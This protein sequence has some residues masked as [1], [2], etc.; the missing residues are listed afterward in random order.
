M[1]GG[2]MSN[3][4]ALRVATLM[5]AE[6]LGLERDLGSIEPGKLADLVIL[7]GNPLEN[8]RNTNTVRMVMAN[9]RLFDGNTLDETWPRQRALPPQPWRH[10]EPR[11]NSGI[12]P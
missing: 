3:H 9:G 8:L 7:D 12:R 10:E 6:A 11:T 1:A 5:G 4:D 2:G